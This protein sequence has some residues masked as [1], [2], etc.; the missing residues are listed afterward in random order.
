MREL[1]P[2]YTLS[3]QMLTLLND[4]LFILTQRE[5]SFLK[6]I[7]EATPLYPMVV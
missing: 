1:P 7:S 4:N 6:Y 5:L 3:F 2:Q